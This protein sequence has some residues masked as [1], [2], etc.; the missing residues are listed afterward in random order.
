MN[1]YK[2]IRSHIHLYYSETPIEVKKFIRNALGVF[3]T[4]K[5]V[6][7]Y[8]LVD[9]RIIDKPL[10]QN[11][12]KGTA[13]FLNNCTSFS[14][15]KAINVERNNFFEGVFTL[16]EVSQL[17]HWSKNVLFIADGCNGLELMVLYM[18]FIICFSSSL[19]KK[20]IFMIF[21]LIVI[22]CANILRCAGLAFLKVKYNDYFDFSHHYTFK[23]TLYGIIFLMW[24]LYTKQYK[25]ETV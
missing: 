6:Y 21:G 3:V 12:G 9:E 10:T 16:T 22:Y 5:A 4:W 1:I 7:Y 17:Q 11:V 14:G 23:I 13:W 20:L 19:L 2:T 18:G 25:N 15:F 8:L 24:M